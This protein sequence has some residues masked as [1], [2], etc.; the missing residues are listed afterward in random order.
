MDGSYILLLRRDNT[1]TTIGGNVKT[2]P[3]HKQQKSKKQNKQARKKLRLRQ[4]RA[5]RITRYIIK[6]INSEYR[7]ETSAFITSTAV[8]SQ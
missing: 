4:M 1:W 6:E 2:I 5:R 7:K 3:D 8:K